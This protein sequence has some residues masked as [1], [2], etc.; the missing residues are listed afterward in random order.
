MRMVSQNKLIKQGITYTDSLF[1]EIE[2][3]LLQSLRQSDTLEEFIANLP[4]DYEVNPLVATGYKDKM[5][6]LILQET[7]NH[8]FSRPSQK[9]LTRVT[10]ESVVGD[11]IVDV[12]DDIRESVRDIVKEGYNNSLSQDEIA[13]QITHKVNTI[14]T[15][16]ARAIARTEI[17]R[18]AVVSD[19]IINKERGATHFYVEC[20]NTACQICKEAWHEDW[21]EENDS[22]YNPRD[23]SAGGKGWIGDKVYSMSD[24]GMLPPVHPNCRCVA[25]FVSDAEIPKGTVMVKDTTTTTTTTTT[26]PTK[27]QLTKNLTPAERAK[28]A[29]YK[30][31]IDNHTKWLKDNPN[32]SPEQINNHKAK[33]AKAQ[34]AFEELRR[35]ALGGVDGNVK[36]TSKPKPTPKPEPKS[37]PKPKETPKPKPKPV[38]EPSKTKTPTREQLD[39]NLTAAQRKEYREIKDIM[40][41]GEKIL[42]TGTD[43]QK[44][45]VRKQ[46][47][48]YKD[49]WKELNDIALGLKPKTTSS[50]RKSKKKSKPKKEVELNKPKNARL[51]KEE[52][53]SLSFEQLAEHHNAKYKGILKNPADGKE[54]HVFEQTFDNGET[55]QLNFEKGAVASYRNGGV[56]T[57]NEII[58]ECFKVPEVLRKETNK[59][60]FRNTQQ[61]LEKNIK[62]KFKSFRK[63]VGG[64]NVSVAKSTY[65]F[66][67]EYGRDMLFDPDHQICINPKSFKKL[68]DFYD[69][70]TWRDKG[71]EKT[72]WKHIIHHEFSHSID[73]SRD[74]WRNDKTRLSSREDYL[75]I[76]KAEPDFTPYA[77]ESISESFAE[78]AGYLSYMLANPHDQ[79]KTITIYTFER[80]ENGRQIGFKPIQEEITFDEYKKRF[81]KHYEYFT[82]LLK[83]GVTE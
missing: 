34:N 53:D 47:A 23:K 27:E 49:R 3:R 81:P 54:Y 14:K 32:A 17:A 2:N 75:K 1:K 43:K 16:R 42:A 45:Y 57:A 83:E 58:H 19:Y 9:E 21:T 80:D 33:L 63:D 22:T 31:V 46:M 73:I 4:E 67:K 66:F 56:A 10:I 59:I 8:K 13:E 35:K 30:R 79:S 78:H 26:E 5:L 28:Y 41:W 48:E 37:K 64:H 29:N 50:K 11:R 24:T 20:R 25:Y 52:A 70:L 76:E 62:G 7:N 44:D 39:N 72:S 77:H 6:D 12:G 18:T 69:I 15:K 51:T 61:G 60:Y 40:D 71:N 55:F 36:P 68:K 38:K 82:K 65:N 74:I